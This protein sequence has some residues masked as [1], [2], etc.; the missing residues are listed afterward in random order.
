MNTIEAY[1]LGKTYKI[2][3]KEA[4]HFEALED[5]S[6]QISN[7]E[8]VGVIGRNGAGKSTLLKLLAGIVFPSTGKADIQ[9]TF[10]SL[11]EGR[12]RLSS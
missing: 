10:S 11:I 6:F 5:A 9:G 8:S 1:G 2:D 7:G 4:S 12:H 3:T